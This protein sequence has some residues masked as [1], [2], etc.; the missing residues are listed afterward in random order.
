[1][2]RT[3]TNADAAE[4]EKW[5]KAPGKRARPRQK[6]NMLRRCMS[7]KGPGPNGH[8]VR[9]HARKEEMNINSMELGRGGNSRKNGGRHED[10]KM[11]GHESSQ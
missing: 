7:S 11:P 4:E 9:S 1:M 5:K 2:V 10:E 6:G 8:E 3:L